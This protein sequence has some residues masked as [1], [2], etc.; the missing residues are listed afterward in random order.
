MLKVEIYEETDTGVVSV[1]E[2]IQSG[3]VAS[4]YKAY[5]IDREENLFGI[6]TSGGYILL[7]FDGSQ[8]NQK[9]NVGIIGT[10]EDT[11]GLVIDDYLYV[12]SYAFRVTAI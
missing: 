3:S 8:L 7:H 10:L 2:Y 1:C 6:P 11:R 4:N 12:F 9:A 5:Y